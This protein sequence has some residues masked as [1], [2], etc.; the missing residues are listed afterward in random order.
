MD[1]DA[2]LRVH[3]EHLVEEVNGLGRLVW[4]QLLQVYLRLLRQRLHIL[5]GILV[6][7]LLKSCFVRCASILDDQ[8]NLLDIVLTWE[9]NTA[10][11]HFAKSAS[12]RPNVHLMVIFMA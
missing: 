9:H 8:I 6:S 7:D 10:R 5:Q 11:H 2:C 12:R 3:V 4:K 1:L